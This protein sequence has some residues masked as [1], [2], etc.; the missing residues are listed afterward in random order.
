MLGTGDAIAQ[1]S[2]NLLFELY[3]PLLMLRLTSLIIAP[4]W[5]YYAVYRLHKAGLTPQ[6]L[7]IPVYMS[8]LLILIGEIIGRFLFYAT[9]IRVGV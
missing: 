1:T 2:L 5:M 7:T 9:H 3:T 8:C 6:R 4:C